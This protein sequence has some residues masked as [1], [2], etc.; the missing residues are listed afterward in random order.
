VKGK[1]A[2]RTG[3]TED[4]NAP[5]AVGGDDLVE[6]VLRPVQQL[7]ITLAA[8]KHVLKIAAQECGVLVRMF[9][10]GV[11]ERQTFHHTDTAFAK[12][13]GSIDCEMR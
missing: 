1:D 7:A 9:L 2:D 10:R 3:V 12:C 6:L 8:C 5:A 11:F 4:H 13:V